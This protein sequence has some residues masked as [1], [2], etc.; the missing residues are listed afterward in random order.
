VK[1]SVASG[2]T[3]LYI[4]IG[5][6]SQSTYTGGTVGAAYDANYVLAWHFGNG[7]TLSYDDSTSNGDAG[8]PRGTVSGVSGQLGGGISFPAGSNY[9]GNSD[10]INIKTSTFETWVYYPGS[11]G[12]GYSLA[13]FANGYGSGVFDKTLLL[14]NLSAH[15][16]YYIYSGSAST[17]TASSAVSSATWYQLIGTNDGTNVNIYINGVL[18]GSMAGGN[19]YTGF[20]EPDIFL[21]SSNSGTTTYYSEMRVSSIARSANW[22]TTQYNAESAPSTF[23]TVGP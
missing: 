18:A 1:E 7:T 15:P 2:G 4:S 23:F 9:V 17:A 6:A 12:S 3:N 20:G 5:N 14:Q 10:T 11:T 22:I 16:Q 19:S 21:N 13:T 8:N